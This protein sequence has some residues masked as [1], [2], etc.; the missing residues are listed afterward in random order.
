MPNFF[1]IFLLSSTTISCSAMMHHC[2]N[3]GCLCN[4]K[5]SWK[6]FTSERGL[7]IHFLKSPGCKAYFKQQAATSTYTQH[8]SSHPVLVNLHQFFLNWLTTGA[9]RGLVYIWFPQNHF[10]FHMKNQLIL[11]L[12][13]CS[14]GDISLSTESAS[15]KQV[16]TYC[17]QPLPHSAYKLS[18]FLANSNVQWQSQDSCSYPFTLL[19]RGWIPWPFTLLIWGWIQ[20]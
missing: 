15:N 16:N 20:W 9:L 3:P 19:V 1:I 4:V 8:F 2:P 10:S 18:L 6:P 7:S 5:Q 13:F 12:L 17:T 11:V 14:H